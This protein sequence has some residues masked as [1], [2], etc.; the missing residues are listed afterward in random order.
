[1]YVEAKILVDNDAPED[2]DCTHTAGT[3]KLNFV[4]PKDKLTTE[5]LKARMSD[6]IDRYK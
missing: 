3:A 6:L 1:M 4:V 5:N 2:Y